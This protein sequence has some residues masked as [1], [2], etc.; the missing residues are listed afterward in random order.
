MCQ[1]HIWRSL[2]SQAL[3]ALALLLSIGPGTAMAQTAGRSFDHLSTGFP[4]RGA[5][6]NDKFG[7]QMA[8]M[9]PTVTATRDIDDVIGYIHSAGNAR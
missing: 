4:L 7:R 3:L 5:H 2:L 1:M 6:A 8:L 9:A